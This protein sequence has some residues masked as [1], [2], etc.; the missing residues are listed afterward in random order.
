M[1]GRGIELAMGG[2]ELPLAPAWLDGVRD[3]DGTL[4]HA[5]SSA[6]CGCSMEAPSRSASRICELK[7]DRP[8]EARPP[9]LGPRSGATPSGA[10]GSAASH[11][12][13]CG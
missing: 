3:D 6:V 7:P 2:E 8:T 11:A 5:W 13:I 4:E 12:G 1:E 9:S 10:T